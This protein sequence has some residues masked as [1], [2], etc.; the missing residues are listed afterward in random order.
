MASKAEKESKNKVGKVAIRTLRVTTQA[1][2]VITIR[3][4]IKFTR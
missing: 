4:F 3:L 2:N 1:N